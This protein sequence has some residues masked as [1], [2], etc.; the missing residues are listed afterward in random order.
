MICKEGKELRCELEM[1]LV[2]IL[3]L[4]DTVK[5]ED[6]EGNVLWL[7]WT[8]VVMHYIIKYIQWL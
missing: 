7:H 5:E 4:V 2:L 3:Q 6:E 1:R 8:S